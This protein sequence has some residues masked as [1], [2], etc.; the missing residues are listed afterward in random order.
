MSVDV[1][2]QLLLPALSCLSP[3]GYERR[4]YS[5]PRP[6]LI[7]R[8]CS[9]LS[10][11][12]RKDGYGIITYHHITQQ[13]KPNTL[14]PHPPQAPP[15]ASPPS[16][17]LILIPPHHTTPR[18]AITPVH[19]FIFTTNLLFPVNQSVCSERNRGRLRRPAPPFLRFS[20]R[21]PL[22][23]PSPSFLLLASSGLLES[24]DLSSACR[25]V[26]RPG[27]LPRASGARFCLLAVP[28]PPWTPRPLRR[29]S[30]LPGPWWG[31]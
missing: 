5:G 12:L 14:H 23:S 19:L 9:S 25:H 27:A 28:A 22:R 21:S 26:G 30:L 11:F 10:S 1:A 24:V 2:T 7:L 16:E 3:G 4:G 8:H 31:W 17:H 18:S 13:G 6:S 15:H 20:P 29:A